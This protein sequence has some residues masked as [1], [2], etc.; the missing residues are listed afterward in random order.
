VKSALLIGVGAY[1]N[2][3]LADLDSP[4]SDVRDWAEVLRD[5]ELGGFDD[6]R[7]LLDVDA[8]VL[9]G[10]VYDFLSA[11]KPPDFLL[12]YYSGHGRLQERRLYLTATPTDPDRLP[13]TA[14]PTDE[15]RHWVDECRAG[16]L[17]LILDCCYAGAFAD[18]KQWG[19]RSRIVVVSAG[20][21]ELAHEGDGYKQ[22][23]LPS[24][25][26]GP[27]LEGL[28]T[29][30]AD[31]DGNGI[32]SV[33]EAFEY[34]AA[35][36]AV[37]GA[38]RRQ[39]PQMRAAGVGDLILANAPRR[40]GLIPPALLELTRSDLPSAR[41]LAADELGNWLH[42]GHRTREQLTA[43]QETLEALEHDPDD[44]VAALARLTL[45]GRV[46]AD[47]AESEDE[48]GPVI[49]A[50][51]VEWVAGS[52]WYEINV[53]TF[54]D[55]DADG[56]GDLRGVTA[57]LDYLR[58]LGVDCLLLTPIMRSPS[59]SGGHDVSDFESIDG[60][61]GKMSDLFELLGVAH[62]HGMR[63]VLDLVLN[64]TSD[65]HPWFQSSRG[66]RD[67]PHGDFY[68]WSD[69]G[70]EY[71]EAA[72]PLGSPG[73]GWT[74]DTVRGQYFWH[75]YTHHEPDLNYDSP[76]VRA[77]MREVMEFWLRQG[78]DG[79]RLL[80]V[81]YLVERSGT[82]SKGL[83]ETHSFLRDIRAWMRAEYGNRV[84]IAWSDTWPQDAATY[85]G[86]DDE[87]QCDIVMYTS[88]MPSLLLALQRG[89][90]RPVSG[91][92]AQMGTPGAHRRWAV[93][94]RNGDEMALDLLPEG[95]RQELMGRF[96]N[97][98][99]MRGAIGIRRRMAG[100]LAND[101]H[102]LELAY[103]L[104]LSMPGVPILYY[105][106]EI[107]MG[108]NL[109]LPGTMAIKT[110]MQWGPDRNGGFSTAH[111]ES[112]AAPVIH[113]TAAGY[114]AVNVED[115]RRSRSSLLH[116]IEQLIERRHATPAFVSP[117]F[118]ILRSTN[119]A[120]LAFVRGDDEVLCLYNFSRSTQSTTLTLRGHAGTTPRELLGGAV[121]PA[122]PD[123]G[124]YDIHLVGHG[125][126]WFV[127]DRAAGAAPAR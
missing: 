52:V 40:S 57:R 30:A 125:F 93:F 97:L 1:A 45:A 82:S 51:G 38:N 50:E 13:P 109:S 2:P 99:R 111:P 77:A 100:L 4:A 116:A 75:R 60:G 96:A 103:A 19:D 14:V 32:I 36:M 39:T 48:P 5:P 119:P 73:S 101:Q 69:T 74:F 31:S 46:A 29:G 49:A 112:L 83:D 86:T 88:L 72:E 17:V 10:E 89:A 106:D 63:V 56:H 65:Q 12:I 18:L 54:F 98:A 66:D 79:L 120:V 8:Q 26:S 91:V 55:A 118:R 87:P 123:S 85:F 62:R 33:R 21:T 90:H 71:A 25:F 95:E 35:R 28:R 20:S 23:A 67:G 59:Q 110:P 47:H 121:F 80:T 53:R 34:A 94:L 124:E 104:L 7:V 81:P 70:D 114:M 24:A 9:Q 92:L 15:L 43:V 122:V 84:L 107:G 41:V 102:Q 42:S 115:Q 78:I 113:E 68:V 108:E 64:H 76:A 37:G 61:L 127:L 105:G 126:L 6:V 22:H 11:A 44:R 27:F 58:W 16:S 117:T 3:Q